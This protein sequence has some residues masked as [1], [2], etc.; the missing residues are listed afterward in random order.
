[1]KF[2]ITPAMIE[3]GAKMFGDTLH[4][5]AGFDHHA[6]CVFEAMV[7][8]MESPDPVC[9]L[10]EVF[11]DDGETLGYVETGKQGFPVYSGLV[12]EVDR[13]YYAAQRFPNMV[14]FTEDGDNQ[15]VRIDEIKVPTQYDKEQILMALQ[16]LHDCYIDTDFLAVNT[17]VHMYHNPDKI[18]VSGE[19]YEN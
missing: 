18:V 14:R 13:E 1:M 8:A 5:S 7:N 2:E 16:Y 10:S 3:A 9:Y 4:S 11:D 15:F 19:E 17:L 12:N 6:V